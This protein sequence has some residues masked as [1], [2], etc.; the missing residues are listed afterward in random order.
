MTA[1]ALALSLA[2]LLALANAATA[3]Y[4]PYRSYNGHAG[5][6][7]NFVVAE[8][9][10]EFSQ[11]VNEGYGAEL[12]GRFPL[13]PLGV[14]SF[15][16]DLGFLIYGYE[17][18]RVCVGDG[19]GCRVQARL[20]TSNNIFFGGIGPELAIP[21]R[22]GRPYVNAFVGFGYFNT[23][24]NLEDLWGGE[25]YFNTQHL[26]DGGLAW[27]AGWGLEVNLTRGRVPI[28]L[29]F[30]ARYHNHGVKEYLTEGDIVDNSDGSI[31]LFPVLSEANMMTYRFGVNVGIPRGRDDD[32]GRRRGW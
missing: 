1:R 17:S 14:V 10:G 31:T 16:G 4:R 27:G 2:A 13:D 12:T 8:P 18:Q 24:S 7:I 29:N 25:D 20:E 26:A 21:T 19:Y 30:G 23:M 9:T 11:F 32:R 28:A 5:V 15:R 22:W 3:Q 6:G